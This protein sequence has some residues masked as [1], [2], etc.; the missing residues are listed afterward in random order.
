MT[1]EQVPHRLPKGYAA[2]LKRIASLEAKLKVAIRDQNKRKAGVAIQCTSQAATGQGCGAWTPVSR[3]VYIQTHW[4]TH[5]HGC[6]G[7]DYW[8]Q[9]EGQ[10]VCPKCGHRN[11]LYESPFVAEL[12]R[13]FKGVHDTYDR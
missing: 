12:K 4:Y 9:G 1:S 3:L 11:R 13:F 8:N 7:G 10:W 6:T 2:G 5:P